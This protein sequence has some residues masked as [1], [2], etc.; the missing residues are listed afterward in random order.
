MGKK[1]LHKRKE[2]IERE[3]KSM[4]RVERVAVIS[5]LVVE[6]VAEEREEK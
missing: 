1:R 3:K 2:G 4:Q 6:Q 5:G